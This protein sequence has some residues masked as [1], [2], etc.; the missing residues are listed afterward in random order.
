MGSVSLGSRGIA[1]HRQGCPNLADIPGDRIIPVSWN[2]GDH[3]GVRQTYP[4]EVRIEVIDRVGVLK[5]ILSHLS[6][7]QINVHKAQVKTFPGQTAE[8]DLGLDVRDHAHLD[9]TFGQIRK[10][11]D[12]LKIRR[13]SE[14]G[15]FSTSN[16]S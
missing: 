16:L 7:L 13:V 11:T 5:D 8:I 15:K 6:D 9:Q 12:V 14:G 3:N 2:H 1:I 4:V 10:M